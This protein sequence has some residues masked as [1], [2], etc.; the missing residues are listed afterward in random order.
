MTTFILVH[1]AWHGPWASERLTP[2]LHNAGMRTLTPA[3]TLEGDA[4][5]DTHVDEVLTCLDIAATAG[6]DV[7]LVGHSYA[8]LI[9]RQAADLQPDL[10]NH[11][12]LIDGWAGGDGA[13]MFS[14]VPQAFV[15]AIRAAAHATTDGCHI[16]APPPASYG[17]TDPDDTR[18]LAP[19]LRPQPLRTFTEATRL[20]GAVDQIPGTAICCRPQPYPFDR[21]AAA[22]GYP[23][24]AMN[25]PHNVMLTHPQALAQLLLDAVQFNNK[26]LEE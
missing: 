6:E 9:V 3:L 11:V 8:G 18:W 1:G 25:G 5:L 4:G 14:L 7:V 26:K 23:T 22:I 2:F 12:I 21:L 19:R 17:I 20:S 16:P 15:N 10:V 24:I 13:S